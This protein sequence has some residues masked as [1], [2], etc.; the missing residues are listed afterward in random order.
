[1]IPRWIEYGF[2]TEAKGV[3]PPWFLQVHGNSVVDISKTAVLKPPE[4][5]ADHLSADLRLHVF[6]ADCLPVL[7]F[8]EKEDIAAV[9]CGW[10][11]ALASIVTQTLKHFRGP[12]QAI[13][14]PAIGACCFEV[15]EDFYKGLSRKDLPIG[16]Y[17]KTED[18]RTKC[19]LVSFVVEKQLAGITVHREQLALHGL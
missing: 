13:L 16:S 8:G 4:A 17:L 12:T 7:L 11:G 15:R 5:D 18:G 6:T 2:E 14:G 19:D 9:H 3:T 10:R 1:M